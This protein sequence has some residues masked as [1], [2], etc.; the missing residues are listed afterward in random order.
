VIV[1]QYFPFK[2]DIISKS[3]VK[4]GTALA[5][6][7]RDEEMCIYRPANHWRLKGGTLY[8][9]FRKCGKV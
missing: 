4:T 8:A 7:G 6:D 9:E 5:S 1:P 3:I 2:K